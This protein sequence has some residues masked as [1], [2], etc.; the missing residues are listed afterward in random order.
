MDAESKLY[1]SWLRNNHTQT[2]YNGIVYELGYGKH[3][4]VIVIESI[5]YITHDFRTN[6]S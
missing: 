2:K 5:F 6:S 4:L 3:V 1:L